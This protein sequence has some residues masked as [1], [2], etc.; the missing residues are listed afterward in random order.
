MQT[1]ET[2]HAVRPEFA[3]YHKRYAEGVT[4]KEMPFI[5]RSPECG[6]YWMM[7]QGGK[8]VV[9][10]LPDPNDSGKQICYVG[11]EK[12]IGNALQVWPW[13]MGKH[14]SPEL[15]KKIFDGGEWPGEVE[16]PPGT[17]VK[18]VTP[19]DAAPPAASDPAS[20]L[21]PPPLP[22]DGASAMLGHNSGE[23]AEKSEGDK[24]LEEVATYRDKVLSFFASI[25]RRVVD[26]KQANELTNYAEAL[27]SL[28]GRIT[29]VHKLEKDPVAEKVKAIDDK[30]LRP[31]DEL[32][33]VKDEISRAVN[34][35]KAAEQE[36]WRLEAEAE[37]KRLREEAEAKRQ[38]E[39][40]AAMAANDVEAAADI[41]AA[42]IEVAEVKPARILTGGQVSGRRQGVKTENKV[43]FTDYPKALMALKDR[44][45]I[46]AAVEAAIM[47]LH[48]A[49][50][51]IVGAEVKKVPKV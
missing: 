10:I 17:P 27:S 21:L 45:D 40:A 36:R 1:Q 31:R 3:R 18:S 42:P 8:T 48:K 4:A 14:I 11:R 15:A 23:K 5:E 49:G 20:P 19:D 46:R 38:E 50:A 47:K 30:Y 39:L 9:A 32:D 22:V 6:Y 2:A 7:S 37:T 43:I 26:L 28:R 24:L 35:W 44:D 25:K 13:L 33:S 51:E 29:A 41:A 16:L 34:I 12:R